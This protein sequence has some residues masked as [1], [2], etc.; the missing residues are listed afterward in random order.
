MHPQNPILVSWR[1]YGK[2][3]HT[4]VPFWMELCSMPRYF[5][6]YHCELDYLNFRLELIAFSALLGSLNFPSSIS[7]L[8]IGSH[9]QVTWFL[10][11]L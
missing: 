11:E 4:T 9:L 8:T 6:K 5:L 1:E 2:I 10:L 3:W 7:N